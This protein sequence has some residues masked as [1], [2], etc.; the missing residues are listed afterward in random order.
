M[1]LLS[2]AKSFFRSFF[3][4]HEIDAELDDE[5]RSTV[6]LLVDQKMHDGVPPAEARRAAQ[7]ELGGVEQ[8]KEQV[9]SARVGARFESLLQDV[10]FGLRMFG[11]TPG[12]TAI[13]ILTLALGMAA[14]TMVF[15]VVNGFLLRPLPV[16]RPDEISRLAANEKGAA[17]PVYDFSHAE[18]LDLQKQATAFSGVFA[19]SDFL[20]GLNFGGHAD[21]IFMQFVSGNF[22]SVLGVHPSLGRLFLPDEGTTLGADA[23]AV[24]AH[25]YWQRQFGGDPAI[26]GR[27]VLIDGRRVTVIGVV[28]KHFHG[29]ETLIE[30]DAYLPLSMM[31][32]EPGGAAAWT[33]RHERPLSVMAR[34]RPGVSLPSAQS[35]LSVLTAR[36][37]R[38]YPATDQ[39]MT[40]RV[41]PERLAR[42]QPY[43]TNIV[44]IIAGFFLT[45]A[46]LVLVLAC[47]N[48]ANILL[49][50]ASV[51]YREMS[52]R[53][54]LG[55]GRGRLMRQMLTESFLLA[56]FG[57][58][59]GVLL[60]ELSFKIPHQALS[61]DGTPVRLDV[62]FDWRV[63]A[64]CAA[65]TLLAAFAAG[66]WPAVRAS[67]ANI[68]DV[69]HEEG[70]GDSAS[71]DHH[72][73]RKTLVVVQVAGSL[74]LLVVAGLFLRSFQGAE[75]MNLGFNPDHVLNLI[76]DPADVGYRRARTNEFYRQLKS[77][78]LRLPGVQSASLAYS[79]PMGSYN[80]A[81][82]IDVE[83][84]PVPPGQQ[85]PVVL[86]NSVGPN[87]F[88]NLQVPLLR[89]RTFTKADNETAPPVAVVNQTMAQ[90]LWPGQDPL[91]K[92]FSMNGP[93]GRF[94]EVVGVARN[95]KYNFVA[96]PPLSYFYVPLAQHFA[97]MRALQIRTLLPP[98]NLLSAVRSEVDSLDPNM[99]IIVLQ[100]MN[101]SLEGPN[102]F[103]VFRAGSTTAAQIGLVGLLL[104]AIGVYGVVSFTT[105]LR[106]REIGIRMALGASRN[107]VLRLVMGQGFG[108]VV[109]GILVGLFAAWGLAHA[110]ASMLVGVAPFDPATY[111]AVTILLASVGF[112][113][114]YVPARR[115]IDVQP[116]MAL[117][118][119]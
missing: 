16:P 38:Q 9:R 100:T 84:R 40:V 43:P 28:S 111:A 32:I 23:Y 51:R 98:A 74:M 27:Q 15:S 58:A 18:F 2:L 13:L 93:S 119:E 77:R 26:I 75:H 76:L 22:F 59:L 99:P 1:R 69:L 17:L 35:A 66:I 36:W 95:G 46:A 49:A 37:A 110:M 31:T 67:R 106:R 7:M 56:L 33:D 10:H 29:V 104:A 83:G 82:S 14:N 42:P 88:A 63:F 60:G 50:R 94:I 80:H 62:G 97:T 73:V 5:I 108:L 11:N 39:G 19:Y 81:A 103:F 79:V 61:L 91:G 3:R 12:L 45:I 55:A 68:G 109:T 107:H 86:Y 90:R 102:G 52:V 117:R 72:R 25:S 24:L 20:G 89:G 78:I 53:A 8:V 118:H 4:K 48:V 87:Y 113:A 70:R 65:A 64:Y 30:P 71:K 115:A 85:P 96:E 116:M 47:V 44:P 105:S 92:R 34:R 112:L 54:A 6:E 41:I 21:P 114:C 57:G 101:Q